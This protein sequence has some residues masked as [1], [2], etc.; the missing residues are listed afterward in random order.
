DGQFLQG[1]DM[2]VAKMAAMAAPTPAE[3]PTPWNPAFCVV[4]NNLLH[5]DIGGCT[6][7]NSTTNSDG[8]VHSDGTFIVNDG[9]AAGLYDAASQMFTPFAK[10]AISVT[11]RYQALNS[12]SKTC[13]LVNNS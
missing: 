3:P 2:I 5:V 7:L 9:I 11:G 12:E 8:S 1:R 10:G 13:Q 6:L 4:R